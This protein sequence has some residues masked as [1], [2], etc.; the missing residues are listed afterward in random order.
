MSTLRHRAREIAFQ[1]LFHEQSARECDIETFFEHFAV[2]SGIR[3]FAKEL[4]QGTLAHLPEIDEKISGKMH[5]DWRFSRLALV[6]KTILR[7]AVY[8]IL[9]RDDIPI[10]V[11]INEAIELAKRYGNES[12][13]SFTNAI[14]DSIKTLKSTTPASQSPQRQESTMPQALTRPSADLN[15]DQA[16]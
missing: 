16:V 13:P 8:E 2:P 12:S 6:D 4:A 5:A 14:L 1:F 15:Q 7:L 11:A 10:S 9:F 3:A